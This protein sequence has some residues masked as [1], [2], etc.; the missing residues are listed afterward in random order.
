MSFV[1]KLMSIFFLG[2]QTHFCN[3]VM[4]GLILG[5]HD[6][7]EKKSIYR[8]VKRFEKVFPFKSD[9]IRHVCQKSWYFTKR[10]TGLI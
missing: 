3:Q 2:K 8:P 9:F 5:T 4:L 1:G 10:T 6:Y 7:F